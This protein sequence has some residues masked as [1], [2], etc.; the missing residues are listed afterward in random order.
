MEKGLELDIVNDIIWLYRGDERQ[1]AFMT[2]QELTQLFY[3]NKEVQMWQ[4]ELSR[5]RGKSLI[6]SPSFTGA[7]ERGDISDR[8]DNLAA[9]VADTEAIIQGKLVEI[10]IQRKKII[11]Y[12]QSVE[13]SLMRQILFYRHVSGMGWT[14]VALS[15]GG[16]N[17]ADGVRKMHDRFLKE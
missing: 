10:Q 2:K 13:D 9:S 7:Q 12:I 11:E 14:K 5:M 16:N 15:I 1:E 17:T 4:D 6:G 8:T 3:L